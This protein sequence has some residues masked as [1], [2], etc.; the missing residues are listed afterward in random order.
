MNR[1]KIY[2]AS[3]DLIEVEG[4]EGADEFN[5]NWNGTLAGRL[6]FKAPSGSMRVY[7][8]Y[9][10]CWHFS[11]GQVSE[12]DKLPAWPVDIRQESAYS[13]LLEIIAP[14]DTVCSFHKGGGDA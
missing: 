11:V 1:I 9:D 2:G 12:D 7:C 14:P 3:D 4:C 8:L 5:G 6:D 10:G 13:T